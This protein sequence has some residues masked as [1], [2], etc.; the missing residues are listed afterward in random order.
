V[1]LELLELVLLS[2]EMSKSCVELISTFEFIIIQ[3]D[4]SSQ[5]RN[6]VYETEQVKVS[7]GASQSHEEVIS[8]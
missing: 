1:L 5:F 2:S 8:R 6:Y 3:E 7:D 4:D